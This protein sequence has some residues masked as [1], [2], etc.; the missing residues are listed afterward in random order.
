MCGSRYYPYPHH[1][2][3]LEIPRKKGN[4]KA[5]LFN[6]K[7]EHKLEFSEEWGLQTKKNPLWGSMSIFRNNTISS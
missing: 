2:G 3:S 1:R 7:F 6:G 4:L 5:K